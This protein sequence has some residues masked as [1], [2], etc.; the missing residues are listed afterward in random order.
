MDEVRAN[1]DLIREEILQ[2]IQ[3]M[4]QSDFIID[5]N[6]SDIKYQQQ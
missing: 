1:T 5:V 3:D 2:A 6:F 4:Y